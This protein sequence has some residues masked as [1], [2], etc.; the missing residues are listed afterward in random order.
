ML[1]EF[2]I[3]TQK[4]PCERIQPFHFPGCM[5]SLDGC[6]ILMGYALMV[7][8][9]IHVGH[10]SPWEFHDEFSDVC[11]LCIYACAEDDVMSAPI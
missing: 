3:V 4:V 5:T 2:K 7:Q 11:H 1:L 9:F 8:R 10:I 6:R